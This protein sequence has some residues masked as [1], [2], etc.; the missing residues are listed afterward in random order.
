MS[1]PPRTRA[2]TFPEHFQTSYFCSYKCHYR[3]FLSF[4]PTVPLPAEYLQVSFSSW[5]AKNVFLA[6]GIF[7]TLVSNTPTSCALSFRTNTVICVCQNKRA[8]RGMWKWSKWR[9]IRQKTIAS[10]RWFGTS[11]GAFYLLN[12]L[13]TTGS[14]WTRSCRFPE[15]LAI[16]ETLSRKINS[17][18]STAPRKSGC[19]MFR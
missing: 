11:S 16:S 15:T 7:S 5:A 12:G 13:A 2:P 6:C 9:S 3:Q 14:F 4:F 1:T 10:N 19:F 18:F 17:R 8:R